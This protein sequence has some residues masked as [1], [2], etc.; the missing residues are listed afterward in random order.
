MLARLCLFMAFAIA[1][2]AGCEQS[3]PDRTRVPVGLMSISTAQAQGVPLAAAPAPSFSTAYLDDQA[4]VKTMPAATLSYEPL[5]TFRAK[6]A[7]AARKAEAE[8]AARL[9]GKPAPAEVEKTAGAG[10][11]G[12]PRKKGVWGNTLDAAR[13]MMGQPTE[14]ATADADE[15]ETGDEADDDASADEEDEDSDEAS[16]EEDE[17][18]ETDAE[19]EEGS[20]DE[21]VED[22]ES[23]D[24]D[25]EDEDS[26]DEES[27]DE[28]SDEED[29]ED[30]SEDE[31]E[32]E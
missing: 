31:D 21:D 28:E 17:D 10:K 5:E 8:R 24:E 19:D 15:D 22:E 30:P 7:E 26:E 4:A 23:E 11:P 3:A 1:M 14:S 27:E 16:D 12:K 20:E 32:D 18:S 29:E 2:T 9:S 13:R 6:N 25:A